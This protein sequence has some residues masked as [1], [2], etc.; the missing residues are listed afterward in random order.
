MITQ[1]FAQAS[2]V[3]LIGLLV[4]AAPMA[5]GIIFAIAPNERRLGLMRPLSLAGIFAAVCSLLIGLA[6][7]LM[8]LTHGQAGDPV[9]V[10]LAAQGLAEAAIPAF[11]AFAC[12]TVAWVCV[13]LGMRKHS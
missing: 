5:M 10:R 8:A 1:S 12:L 11:V 6:N 9:D 2:L 13:A 4:S 3:A 7:A